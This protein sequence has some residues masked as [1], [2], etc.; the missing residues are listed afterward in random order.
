MNEYSA[1][2]RD[3]FANPRNVGTLA[4]PDAVGLAGRDNG[5]PYLEISVQ[6]GEGH[7]IVQARFRTYGCAAAIAAGSMLTTL[8][9]DRSVDALHEINESVLL[10]ALGGLPEAKR[11]CA[12]L[13][14]EALRKVERQ[15]LAR[16]SHEPMLFRGGEP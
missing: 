11:H 14:I 16:R 1:M 10:D 9:L 4:S 12:E 3:H 2:V 13:A 7:R 6:V 5:G 8:V 15:L